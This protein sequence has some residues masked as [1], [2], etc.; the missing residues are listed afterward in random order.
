MMS[1]TQYRTLVS[2]LFAERVPVYAVVDGAG[3]PALLAML[4]RHSVPNACLYRGELEPELAEA[5]P[6]LTELAPDSPFTRWFLTEGW[7]RNWGILLLS[8][9]PLHEV[10]SHLRRLLMVRLPDQRVV[11][12]RFYDPR[13][14]RT[15]LPTCTPEEVKHFIG[16]AQAFHLEDAHPGTLLRMVLAP[17]GVA[18][19]RLPLGG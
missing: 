16:P 4:E 18:V 6:Y 12:F 17:D 19:A 3:C 11:Y 14:L 7:G 9:V 13:V 15:Y 1:E 2:V 8:D 10:R 5:A